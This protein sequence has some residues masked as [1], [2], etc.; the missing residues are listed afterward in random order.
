MNEVRTTNSRALAELVQEAQG[1]ATHQ[2]QAIV[3]QQ[4]HIH[5]E[6]TKET[7][8]TAGFFGTMR[9]VF[10]PVGQVVKWGTLPWW[11]P[12]LGLGRDVAAT[13]KRVFHAALAPWKQDIQ[14]IKADHAAWKAASEEERRLMEAETRGWGL[15][16]V[17]FLALVL[18]APPGTKWLP[19]MTFLAAS[20]ARPAWCPVRWWLDAPQGGI[21]GLQE[22]TRLHWRVFRATLMGQEPFPKGDAPRPAE[23]AIPTNPQETK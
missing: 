11:G 7:L 20:V 10:R 15:I 2:G 3:I 19:M 18:L 22:R 1:L 9:I 8:A 21:Q 6:K 5:A 14:A 13:P 12:I 4:V 16:S 17:G 23:A